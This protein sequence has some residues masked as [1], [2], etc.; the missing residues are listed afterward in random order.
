MSVFLIALA[1]LLPLS[2]HP[3]TADE[4][5]DAI[6]S[7][8]KAFK[9]K[10]K[11]DIKHYVALLG[12]KYGAAKP[13]QQKAILKLDG[14]ALNHADQEIKD[15]AVEAIAKTADA[16]AA[17]LLTKELDKKT[18][19]DNAPYFNSCVK[20]LGRLK[21]PKAGLDRLVKLLKHKTIDVVAA[22][23]E[24]LG[25]YKDAPFETKKS[26]VEDL[27]KIYGSIASAANDAR[28]ST[29]KAKLAKLQPA[30]DDTLKQL[31]GQEHKS[32][33]DWLK[34]WNDTGKKAAKW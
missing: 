9:E 12:D 33:P 34:W 28:D 10:A 23:T 14:M 2:A 29:A 1:A 7:L 4:V 13:E 26:I 22:S 24:A 16:K 19:E 3:M 32:H 31:T 17:S 11:A 8:E 25:G 5:D 20:A 30:A 27:L 21:D 18:T 15:A 6:A